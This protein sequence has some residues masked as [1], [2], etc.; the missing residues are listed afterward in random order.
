[1]PGPR[2][3]IA[4]CITCEEGISRLNSDDIWL[5]NL[6]G[7]RTTDIHEPEP[8]P[9]TIRPLMAYSLMEKEDA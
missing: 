9:E 2:I 5:H 4:K 6:G 3:E 8:R 7:F 1:M